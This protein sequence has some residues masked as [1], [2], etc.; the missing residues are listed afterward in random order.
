MK[1]Q[2]TAR[3][4]ARYGGQTRE[5]I[6]KAFSITYSQ[7]I[8]RVNTLKDMGVQFHHDKLDDSS[9]TVIYCVVDW[10]PL[11]PDWFLDH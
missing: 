3:L 4:F 7:A 1:W 10:G 8:R 5:T 11:N 2:D 9:G 6:S